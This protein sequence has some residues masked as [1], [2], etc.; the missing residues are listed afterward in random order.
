VGKGAS[1]QLFH[2]HFFRSFI[3]ICRKN[4]NVD[5]L[6]KKTVIVYNTIYIDNNIE[7]EEMRDLNCKKRVRQIDDRGLNNF[8]RKID[9]SAES[10]V[11]F[12]GKC[13]MNDDIISSRG[14]RVWGMDETFTCNFGLSVVGRFN[15]SG[16]SFS[17][18]WFIF[19]PRL[20][21][22]SQL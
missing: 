2:Y 18:A 14:A 10:N 11:A 20:R 17:C 6:K 15:D 7:S 13:G 8:R 12:N 4:N 16:A 1:I 21:V 3:L 22:G 5:N 19:A 9:K